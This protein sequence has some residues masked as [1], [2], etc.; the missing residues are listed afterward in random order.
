MSTADFFKG[1]FK[2]VFS[3]MPQLL[4]LI[5]YAGIYELKVFEI[6]IICQGL[7]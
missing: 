4:F 6:I 2:D 3:N 1:I 5:Q 7:L